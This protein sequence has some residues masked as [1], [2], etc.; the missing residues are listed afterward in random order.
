MHDM[1][2]TVLGVAALLGVA[3]FLPPLAARL[4][5]PFTVLLAVVGCAIGS[6]VL[7]AHDAPEHGMLH[8]L[9]SL[10]DGSKLSSSLFLTVFLPALLFEAA[11][12]TDVR[13]L[14]DD[15]GHVLLLAVGAVLICTFTVG[16]ALAGASSA[17]LLVCLLLGAIVATTDPAAVIGIFRDIGAPRR[18]SILVA[19]ESLLNDAAA[20]VLFVLIAAMLKGGQMPGVATG[21]GMFLLSFIGG[22][23]FG[24]AIGR[25]A[26]LAFPLLRGW[27]LAEVT[28]TVSLAYFAFVIGDRYLAVSGVVAVVV[29]GLVLSAYGRTR[30]TP[31]SWE[32]LVATWEQVGFWANALIFLMA[33]MLVPALLRGMGWGDAWLLVVLFLATLLARAVVLFGLMPALSRMGGGEPVSVQFRAVILWG[34]LR[35]AVS[36]AL[37]LAVTE[38]PVLPDE[39]KRFVAILTTGYVLATLFLNGTTLR[40]LIR[41]LGLDRLSRADREVR[42]R[43]LVLALER[44]RDR[45]EDVGKEEE[46]DP[47]V[48]R[49]VA[50][51]LERRGQDIAMRAEG[52]TPLTE[53]DRVY[54]GLTTI[55]AR[56][57][58]LC[59]EAFREQL[60]GARLADEALA[61]VGRL[62]DGVKMAGRAG[63]E[64]AVMAGLLYPRSFRLALELQY[65]LGKSRWL[66]R[67][68]AERFEYV[69][70]TEARVRQLIRFTRTRLR[71]LL[72]PVTADALSGVL[73]RRLEATR[74][75]LLALKLAFPGFADDVQRRYLARVSWRLEEENY[76]AML[77]E[78][79]ISP[80]VF[81]S[82]ARDLQRRREE[83]D[84]RLQPD[85]ALDR[86]TLLAK[87]PLF[88]EL[89]PA[90]LKSIAR[91][92]RPR[93]ALPGAR[94]VTEG[95]RGDSMYFIAMGAAEVRLKDRTVPL[96]SGQFFGEIALLTRMPRTADVVS[97]SY[98]RLLELKADDF[99][100]LIRADAGLRE[101]INGVAQKRLEENG[102]PARWAAAG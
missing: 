88:A 102:L 95:E 86:A 10:F 101:V 18:L 57:Q 93:L 37:A 38:D 17:G 54:I 74:K 20:I 65:R 69:L 19:G 96:G 47:R 39:A 76:R 23:A 9:G 22:A 51:G 41:W 27:R 78:A 94:V 7:L 79:A 36:L 71:A 11:I 28:L 85:V 16:L 43:A 14:A 72:G 77:E 98:C 83:L 46:I 60:I 48:V 6:V 26:C 4:S 91:L 24:Y 49:Q 63:Y 3:A 75:E 66:A 35:G 73:Q 15:F 1:A 87:V 42:D 70:S 97:L 64:A 8:A 58:E 59:I 68:L 100:R 25:A 33:A 21:I 89:A 56:E 2:L 67:L 55:A 5:L 53:E 12:T 82:M 81:D 92:L 62:A 50:S 61:Q 30:M 80:E 90:R 34:G 99:E 45:I 84:R 31:S 52:D 44:I 13:R 29:A 40:L 32:T